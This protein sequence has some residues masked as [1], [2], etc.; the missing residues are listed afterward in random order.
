[1]ERQSCSESDNSESESSILDG[2]SDMNFHLDNLEL[3][4]QV[5]PAEENM[6]TTLANENSDQLI[7]RLTAIIEG[8][9]TRQGEEPGE[10]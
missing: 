9:R 1:M 10:D 2:L 4:K 7:E 8:F 6:Q 3:D 5:Y